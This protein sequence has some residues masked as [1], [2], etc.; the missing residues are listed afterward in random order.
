MQEIADRA[1]VSRTA[2][3]FVLNNTPGVNIP[4]KTRQR[5]L[6]AARELNYTPDFAARTLATGRSHTVAYIVRTAPQQLA[7]DSLFLS[8]VLSGVSRAV[9]A[10]GYH[11]LLYGIASNTPSSF[12]TNLIRSQRVEGLVISWP[13][14]SD[15]ELY[16]LF[17]AGASIVV[18]GSSGY[19]DIPSVDVD[20]AA[21]AQQAIQHLIDLGHRVIA[22][23]TNGPLDHPAAAARAAG[24]RQALQA[25]GLPYYPQLTKQ[26][27]YTTESG[28]IA[29]RALLAESLPFTAVFVSGDIVALGVIKALRERGLRIPQDVSIIGFDDIP[30]VSYFEPAL[31]TVRLPAEA[32][33]FEAG[34]M[35][36]RAIRGEPLT[37]THRVLPTELIVRESTARPAA[38]GV[39][40]GQLPK[41]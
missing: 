32:I 25:A 10:G 9:M 30:L 7:L 27:A 29:G 2:V 1:G 16:A 6:K 23:V 17:D 18:H 41:S 38:N 39:S 21:S 13:A 15:D 35:L 26:G 40:R 4:E 36:I 24:Y 37:N 12:Y 14:A 20:N 19:A 34:N 31:T 28:L 33:G 8:G 3:S 22:H 11:L 5:I